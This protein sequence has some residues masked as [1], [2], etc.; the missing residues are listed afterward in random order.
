MIESLSNLQQSISRKS[1][2][3]IYLLFELYAKPVGSVA[4]SKLRTSEL[5]M[6]NALELKIGGIGMNLKRIVYE[7][8]DADTSYVNRL[9]AEEKEVKAKGMPNFFGAVHNAVY[10]N[11]HL[12]IWSLTG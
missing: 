9:S 5:H 7:D 3:M 2:Q 6:E 11:C 8:G 1:I 10:L 4:T 12:V